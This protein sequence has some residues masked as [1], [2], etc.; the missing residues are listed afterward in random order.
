MRQASGNTRKNFEE[1][2]REGSTT[3]QKVSKQ[4]RKSVKPESKDEISQIQE[5]EEDEEDEQPFLVID[6]TV[7]PNM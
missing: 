7:A 2:L 3:P 6:V 4:E 5:K 1:S